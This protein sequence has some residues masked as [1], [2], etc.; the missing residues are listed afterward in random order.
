MTPDFSQI[1]ADYFRTLD[2]GKVAQFVSH[3]HKFMK[4]MGLYPERKKAYVAVS[5]GRDSIALAVV[6]LLLKK[7]GHFQK[8]RFLHINH[9]IRE[10]NDEEQVFLEQLF[11]AW[12]EKLIIREVNWAQKVDSNF[13]QEARIGRY[14]IFESFKKEGEKIYLAHHLDDSFEWSLL[15]KMRSSDVIS[16]LGIPLVRGPFTRPFLCVSRNH[17]N[18]F[19]RQTKTP[20][21]E[22]PTNKD[23]RYE[24][25]YL[26]HKVIPALAKRYPGYLKHYAYRSNEL[27][28]KLGVFVVKKRGNVE[29]I[30]NEKA[31]LIIDKTFQNNFQFAHER[32]LKEVH[33]L[34]E[35]KRGVYQKQVS[36]MIEAVKNHKQGPLTLSGNLSAHM[37][38]NLILLTKKS[39]KFKSK[40]K[41]NLKWSELS[42]GEFQQ[43]L[44]ERLQNKTQLTRFPFT[45]LVDSDIPALKRH[46]KHHK[47]AKLPKKL[48]KKNWGIWP[49]FSLLRVW[50]KEPRLRSRTIKICLLEKL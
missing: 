17:I 23:I 16:S 41:E 21:R 5:G 28:K 37:S 2:K 26:R 29:V 27:A 8:L 19:L 36:K 39:F 12:D 6:L 3:V 49:A 50:L 10:G 4:S 47:M 13:E 30:G 46:K 43:Y 34:S 44:I 20:F 33:R 32:I 9:K 22:D 24:R 14:Q 35:S 11:K 40:P 48:S 1:D 25:N 15:Q 31:S 7:R 42:V 45:V 38:D 18:W